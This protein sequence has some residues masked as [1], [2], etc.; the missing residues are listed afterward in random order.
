MVNCGSS[1]T[2]K[3]TH[4]AVVAKRIALVSCLGLGSIILEQVII[5]VLFLVFDVGEF[6]LL[7]GRRSPVLLI[8]GQYPSEP[9]EPLED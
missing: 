7:L 1:F 4:L 2:H 9:G 8:H 3:A 6:W 5:R